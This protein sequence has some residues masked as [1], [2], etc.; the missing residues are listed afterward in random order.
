M[1][2]PFIDFHCHPA[3]K[4]Y[5]QSFS[6]DPAGHNDTDPYSLS[7]L[8]H[9]DPPRLI[10]KALQDW[11]GICKFTQADGATLIHG[12]SRIVCASIYP[13][14]RGFFRDKFG[15]NCANETV[16]AFI[17]SVGKQRVIDIQN[18]SNYFK[19]L[20]TEYAFYR[21]L[22][23]KQ[24]SLEDGNAVYMLAHNWQEISDSLQ[25]P[26]ALRTIHF[27]F[28]IE[29]LH[30]LNE[31]MDA[32]PD[33]QM[34]LRNVQ[35]IKAWEHV[36]F[37]VTF[38]HH[39]NNHLCGH[40][41]SLFD[42]IGRVCDQS[43]AINTGFT[44]L[45]RQV[46]REVLSTQNG[47]R[48]LIDI[49]HMSPLSRKEF[50]SFLETEYANDPIPVIASHAA[51]NGLRSMDEPVTDFPALAPKLLG[52]EINFYDNEIL[53]IAQT[54]GIYG[55]QLDERRAASEAAL[56]ELPKSMFMDAIRE[57]RSSLIWNQIQYVAELLDQHDLPAW[58]CMAL[59]SDFDATIDPLN[60][61]LTAA[62]LPVLNDCLLDHAS[63]YMKG[64]GLNLKPRNQIP[65]S[66]IIEK[67]FSTNGQAFLQKWYK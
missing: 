22:N 40:S 28:S 20:Q 15:N 27:I 10:D 41:K 43:D 36:P 57:N 24:I 45:G 48:I 12:N 25:Q 26:D 37:F 5:G 32:A 8:W 66:T 23:G 1:Q 60:G 2:A 33:P 47:K 62:Q 56:K 31:N 6:D 61:F 55:L 65:A 14:E 46:L 53:M 30:C 51:A 58:D 49:K 29:G 39:F 21:E 52:E 35:A 18:I 3:L 13:I 42:L 19:D 38:A 16:N 4:P 50:F 9:A 34:F 44:D 59:G 17:T 67:I 54:G 11:A 7:S 64:T 63:T